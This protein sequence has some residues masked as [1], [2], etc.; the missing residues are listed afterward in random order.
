MHI[1]EKRC[2]PD[3][4]RKTPGSRKTR[5]SGVFFHVLCC[6]VRCITN[7]DEKTVKNAIDGAV[8]LWYDN[9]INR[10]GGK[11]NGSQGDQHDDAYDVHVL[12]H[13]HALLCLCFPAFGRVVS[14]CERRK[15]AMEVEG[16]STPLL[17]CEGGQCMVRL[18]RSSNASEDADVK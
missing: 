17:F 8:G 15:A 3:G 9:S 7:I 2:A 10:T 16:R 1:D 12:L 4:V 11:Q 13:V 14:L 18:A 6:I 5:G